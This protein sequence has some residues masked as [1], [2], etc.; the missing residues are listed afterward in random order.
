M[1]GKDPLTV[2]SNFVDICIFNITNEGEIKKVIINTNVSI[3]TKEKNIYDY[4]TKE[5]KER[6]KEL[7]D[8]GLDGDR[9]YLEL[10]KPCEECGILDVEVKGLKGETYISFIFYQS[11]QEREFILEEKI[12]QL[13]IEA[14]TD[15]MTKLLNRYGYRERVEA[16][17][18]CGD[19]DRKL[20][21]LFI[22]LDHLKEIND[23]KGHKVGDKAIKQISELISNSIRSRDVAVRYG[24]DEFVIVVEELTGR[25]ST[26][27]GLAER[28]VRNVEKN[29]KKFY[30]TLSI[31]VHVVKVGEFEKYLN[32]QESLFKEWDKALAVADQMV[33]KA[34]ES[35]RNQVVKSF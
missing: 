32:N 14:K 8:S 16:L 26:A 25:K 31:G 23:T 13:S 9:R 4:F 5:S 20:G 12:K 17:L 22:D 19:P 28:L 30:C 21:I 27:L 7:I 2:L 6:L 15:P 18:R 29:G 33:Y 3:N 34:K 1:N 11:H 35:G 24:G 10:K